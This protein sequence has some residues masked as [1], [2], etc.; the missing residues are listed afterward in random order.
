M[1]ERPKNLTFFMKYNNLINNNYYI[2]LNSIL[3]AY[4]LYF[5]KKGELNKDSHTWILVAFFFHFERKARRRGPK[6]KEGIHAYTCNI[7]FRLS[8]SC[9]SQF[10]K[11]MYFNILGKITLRTCLST[12]CFSLFFWNFYRDCKIMNEY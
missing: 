1:Y 4:A 3:I 8:Q 12:H 10:H 5:S 2:Q 11:S 9:W 7:N 6:L